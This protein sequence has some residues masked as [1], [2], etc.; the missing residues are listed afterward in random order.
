MKYFEEAVDKSLELNDYDAAKNAV[1]VCEDEEEKKK[2]F[3]KIIKHI[4]KNLNN[5]NLKEIIN[6][7]RDS[8][9][10]LNLHDI[11]P[12][13][14][15]NTFIECLK[16][17]ICSLLDVYNIKIKAKKEEIKDNLRT[18]NLLNNDIK[19]IKKKYVILNKH[20]ICYICKKNIYYKKFY[21]FSCNHYFHSVCSLN[22][23]INHK[24]KKNLFHFYSILTNY[25]N[26]I[27]SQNE[28]DILLYE[29]K[30]N[31][32]LT[33]ECFICGSFS[34]NSITKSF[35]SQS[36]YDLADSWA[37]SNE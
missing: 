22:L 13:I 11:L 19:D 20:D 2:L 23:Y 16:T 4:S 32:I 12:Y 29:T 18:I 3:L 26:A 31:E 35:I 28:H 15:E 24:S 6:L 37:I 25:K 9:S 27:A 34:I 17:D 21:V 7:I 36:E 5:E 1:L 10:I 8:H 30:I 33:E 14:N